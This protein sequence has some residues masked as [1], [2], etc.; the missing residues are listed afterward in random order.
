MDHRTYMQMALE[1][2]RKALREGEVP[3]GAVV[4]QDG[5]VIARA[6]NR[7]ETTQDPTAHAEILALRQAAQRLR[8]WR[9]E[10]ATL[11]VTLEPCP[12]CAGAAVQA[13]LKRLVYGAP[14]IRAGAVDSVLNLVEHPHFNHRVEVVSGICEEECRLI[15]QEFFA[16][17][18]REGMTR[19]DGRVG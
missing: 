5:E 9:L 12:M 4:V 17:L 11:Y 13:R 14:D 18:R 3:V 19:R 10:G 15:L 7:R 1:E 2:A 8:S 6:Y 16:K